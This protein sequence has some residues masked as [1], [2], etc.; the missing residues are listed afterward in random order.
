MSLTTTSLFDHQQPEQMT[1]NFTRAMQLAAQGEAVCRPSMSFYLIA[2][3]TAAV[4]IS[5]NGAVNLGHGVVKVTPAR[6]GVETPPNELYYASI[7]DR[8]AD[9]WGVWAGSPM[10][11]QPQTLAPVVGHDANGSPTTESPA[12]AQPDAQPKDGG[13]PSAAPVSTQGESQD[14]VSVDAP[15]LAPASEVAAPVQEVVSDG[16]ATAAAG[17]VKEGD[18]AE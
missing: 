11:V 17:G 2:A 1:M 12:A 13:D 16:A 18:V 14:A 9:D 5:P 6:E 3:M 10:L 7:E 4:T 8:G 15:A